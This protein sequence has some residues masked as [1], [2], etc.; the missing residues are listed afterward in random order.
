ML[1]ACPVPDKPK[2]FKLI[3]S[4]IRGAPRNAVGWVFY[5]VKASNFQS[6]RRAR[7]SGLPIYF[8]DNAY[9]DATRGKRFRVTVNRPQVAARYID[10]DCK[11]FDALGLEI[12]PWR[13]MPDGYWLAVHQSEDHEHT[14]PGHR[15]WLQAAVESLQRDRALVH[16]Y[17]SRDKPAQAETLRDALAGAWG[18]VTH[19]S[20]AA[21]RAVLDGVTCIVSEQHALHGMVCS[22][23]PARDERRRFL[24]VL[25]D[26][27][28][29]VPELE[30]GTAWRRLNP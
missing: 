21:V 6:L 5:G 30:D 2:A 17:W 11:R 14:C 27:E 7:R 28:F 1:I 16:R 22:D 23:D 19:T 4:F 18:L 3:G 12:K 15:Q 20:A 9:F 26:H 24:G 25:A 10:S 13:S 8:I 29:T